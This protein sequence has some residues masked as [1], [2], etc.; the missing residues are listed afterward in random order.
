MASDWKGRELNDCADWG[1]ATGVGNDSNYNHGECFNKFPFPAA[2]E[3]QQ[4]KIRAMGEQ[5]DAH[6]KRQQA[7]HPEL[8]MTGMYNV[9]EAVR[10]GTT[11]TAKEKTIYEQGLVGILHEPYRP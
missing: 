7:Q 1:T 8:T 2:T 5:V 10:A 3:A 6:R 9:L 4:A 11:L